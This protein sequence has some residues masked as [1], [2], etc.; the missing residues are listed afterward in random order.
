MTRD[1]NAYTTLK[2]FSTYAIDGGA[3]T[4]FDLP[5]DSSRKL[6]NL[7]LKTLSTE[8]VVG[9]MGVTLVRKD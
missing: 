5:L 4:I 3:A 8:V 2:G 9:L 6:K 1:F 7:I